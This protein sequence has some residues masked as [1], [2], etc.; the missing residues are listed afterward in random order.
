MDYLKGYTI[1]PYKV[2]RTGR[3]AFTD[4]TNN[5]LSANQQTCEAYGYTYDR[6][7]GTCKAYALKPVDKIFNNQ[8][9]LRS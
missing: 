4:G 5:N 6:S 1:K 3:V 7:S 8:S 2:L 9:I